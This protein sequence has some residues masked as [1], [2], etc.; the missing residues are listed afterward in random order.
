MDRPHFIYPLMDVRV[1]STLAILNNVAMNVHVQV[2]GWMFVFI[3]FGCIPRSASAR[4][5]C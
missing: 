5:L 4:L 3:S 1:A 2:F